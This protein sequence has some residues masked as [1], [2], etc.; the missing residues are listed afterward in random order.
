MDTSFQVDNLHIASYFC[1]GKTSLNPSIAEK[2]FCKGKSTLQRL[3]EQYPKDELVK[4][5]K[6]FWGAIKR[7]DKFGEIINIKTD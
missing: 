3:P 5:C 4:R 2:G 1:Q 6:A 7:V